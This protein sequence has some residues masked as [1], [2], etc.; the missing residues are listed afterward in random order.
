VRLLYCSLAYS[1]LS[2]VA[3]SMLAASYVA[4]MELFP[5]ATRVG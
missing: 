3:K 4:F 1:V 5:F 2:V